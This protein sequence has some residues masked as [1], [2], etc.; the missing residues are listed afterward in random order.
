MKPVSQFTPEYMTNQSELSP[1]K[2][3]FFL[4]FENVML[5]YNVCYIFW[6][7]SL[8]ISC[9]LFSPPSRLHMCMRTGPSPRSWVVPQGL[10]PWRK[11]TLLP[12][13]LLANSFPVQC[14][15]F[16][17]PSPFST[18][19]FLSGL[20]LC[21]VLELLWIY[22]CSFP[23]ASGKCHFSVVI[24]CLCLSHCS[25]TVFHIPENWEGVHAFVYVSV[26]VI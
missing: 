19:G 21:T 24:C 4:L 11:Q 16:F 14:G 1:R 22:M 20:I 3:C 8:L 10:H 2:F 26:C 13:A 18:R 7:C 15:I 12:A 25:C 23:V 9:F 17:N 5:A 6:L